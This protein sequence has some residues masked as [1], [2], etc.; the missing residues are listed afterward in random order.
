MS[1]SENQWLNLPLPLQYLGNLMNFQQLLMLLCVAQQHVCSSVV[2]Q[3]CNKHILP[4]KLCGWGTMSQHVLVSHLLIAINTFK[5]HVGRFKENSACS[6][7]QALCLFQPN[8]R[9]SCV[10]KLTHT[11][12]HL[13]H[14][15]PAWTNIQCKTVQNGSLSQSSLT[16][17]FTAIFYSM[18][19]E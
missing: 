9:H 19:T 4:P 8:I 16:Y 1:S 3:V 7:P 18:V 6:P 13:L 14:P 15:H 5:F 2:L 17:F 11:C 12:I 10:A